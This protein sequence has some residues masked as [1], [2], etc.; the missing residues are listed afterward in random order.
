VDVSFAAW[1][2]DLETVV[3]TLGLDDFVLLGI[4]QGAAVA[5]AY[6]ARHPAA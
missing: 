1:V 5:A 3:D 2:E 6:A 4:S